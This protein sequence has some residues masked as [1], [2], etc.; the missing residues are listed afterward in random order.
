MEKKTISKV[1]FFDGLE[2]WEKEK[3]DYL[4]W[5]DNKGLQVTEI[6]EMINRRIAIVSNY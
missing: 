5:L 3:L 2:E 1:T 4:L 6:L